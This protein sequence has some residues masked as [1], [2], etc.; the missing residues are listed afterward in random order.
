MKK[1]SNSERLQVRSE[2][3]TDGFEL[4]ARRVQRLRTGEI[5][6]EGR[7]PLQVIAIAEHA[8][9]VAE[10]SIQRVLQQH[11]PR[12]PFACKEGCAWCCHKRVGTS[13]PE[14]VRI[15]EFLRQR[16]SPEE[17]PATCERICKR[18]EERQ[19]LS[20]QD[21]WAAARLPCPLLVDNRCSVY[22][23]RPLTCRGYNSSDAQA[24]ERS[25][26]SRTRVEVPKYEPQHRLTTFML[27]G[28]RSA[29]AE[30]GLKSELLELT[31]ALRIAVTEPDAI[32]RWLAGEA[33]F[34]P[35]RMP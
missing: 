10:K 25:C 12:R 32:A 19:A 14:V 17:W 33:A 35:A 4:D 2:Q 22:P 31:A 1:Q 30:A 20:Q 15:V 6:N 11:P 5:L 18:D 16:L 13:A 29:L 7:T 23:V 28:M 34:A 3:S 26:K 8:G 24:C 27:D 21:S 9:V